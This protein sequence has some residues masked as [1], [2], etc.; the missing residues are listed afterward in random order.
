M[1]Q[2]TCFNGMHL[3]VSNMLHEIEKEL[4]MRLLK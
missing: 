3:A 1:D 4:I 2:E